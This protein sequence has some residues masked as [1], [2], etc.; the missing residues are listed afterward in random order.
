MVSGE[1]NRSPWI[2]SF[3]EDLKKVS[4]SLDVWVWFNIF[5]SPNKNSES[6]LDRDPYKYNVE[7]KYAIILEKL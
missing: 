2:L 6:A 7:N 1:G 4:S 3:W 5:F